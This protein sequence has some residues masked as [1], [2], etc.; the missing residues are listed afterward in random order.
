MAQQLSSALSSFIRDIFG[1]DQK[2]RQELSISASELV[3]GKHTS[4]FG[5]IDASGLGGIT[6]ALGL[7]RRL[8]HR[9]ADYEQMD[10]YGDINAAL[11]I[12]ADD[13]TQTDST[14]RKSVWIESQDEPVRKELE[15]MLYNRLQIEE[16]VWEIARQTCL[17][18]DTKVWGSGK[19]IK[20]LEP[21]DKVLC[22][23]G[24]LTTV[25]KKVNNGVRDVLRIKTRHRE[26]VATPDH[27][28]L[29]EDEDGNR[30]WVEAGDLF[31][32]RYPPSP[33]RKT[34]NLHD[35]NTKIVVSGF[36]S[37]GTIPSWDELLGEGAVESL[38]ESGKG[39]SNE[40]E[41]PKEI[42]PWFCRL[43]G[44]LLGDG[45]REH[46][47]T[48]HTVVYARGEYEDQND[49]YDDLLSR[50]GLKVNVIDRGDGV[51]SKVYSIKFKR[52]LL[53]LDWIDGSSNKRIP[54]WVYNLPEEFR[55]EFLWGFIDTDGW[56]SSPAT[57]KQSA[58]H[59]EI[60]NR[61]LAY[62]FKTLIDGLGYRSGNIR[63]RKRKPGFKIKEKVVKTTKIAYMLT[64]S[65]IR[66]DEQFFIERVVSV[67][68]HGQTEVFDIEVKSE[69]SSFSAAGIIVHNCKYGNDFE[70]IVV[71]SNG[72]IGLNFLPPATV[73]RV[74]GTG[75]ELLGFV[76]SYSMD[77]NI[78]RN[79]FKNLKT[80]HGGAVSEG[81]DMAVFEDWRVA[82]FRLR[83]K[84]RDSVYGW[85]VTDPAR[86]AWR[87]LILLEDSV[88]VYR[89][90]RSP[91]RYAFYVDVGSMSNREAERAL[92]SV[93]QKLKKRKF[94][95]PRTGKLDFRYNPL[96]F[97]EDFFLGVRDG[98]ESTRVDV[99]NGPSYQQV[100][101]VQYFLFKL[102]AALK[103]PRAYLGYDENQPSKA[104]LCLA[105]DTKIP[106]LD[107]TSPTIEEL[108]KRDDPF[109]VYSVDKYNNMVPGLGRNARLTRKK[110]ATVEVE[111]DNGEII[112]C[113]P[114]H[115]IMMRD[116]SYREAQELNC[117]DSLMPLYRKESDSSMVGYEEVYNP[118]DGRWRFT[119][120]MVTD[121]L[122]EEV[123][124]GD[125]RHHDNFNKRD[126][127]PDNLHVMSWGDH[128]E[129]HARHAEKTLLRPDVMRKRLVA[130]KEWLDSK[131]GQI[132]IRR[133]LVD[134]RGEG[135][136]YQ[137]R[138]KSDSYRKDSSDR[139]L[140]RHADPYDE[141]SRYNKSVR[142][143]ENDRRHSVRMS[144]DG[145]PKW[146]DEA[147]FEV[148][149]DV[150]GSY[151]CTSIAQLSKWT[152]YSTTL[153][154]RLIA[155]EGMTYREFAEEF[156]ISSKF[157]Q[158][159]YKRKYKNHK[160]VAVRVGPV[161]DTYDLTVDGYNNFAIEQGI[162]VHNSQEDVR[163]ARTVLRV[164]REIRN[165]LRKVCRVHLASRR[166]DPA[167]VDFEV[168]MTVPSSIF[169]L[170]QMEVRRTR[171]EIASSMERHVSLY[172]LLSNVY[173]MSD[174]EIS[175][176]MKQKEEE[177]KKAQ[178][179]G[180]GSQFESRVWTPGQPLPSPQITEKELMQGNREH[181]KRAEEFIKKQLADQNNLFGTQLREVGGLLKD[182]ARAQSRR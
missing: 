176:V 120:R 9:Y 37:G 112:T 5:G 24:S 158:N 74:Q 27:R 135:S 137:E 81:K 20:D 115:P 14:T 77:I 29:T 68:P 117:E 1:R 152:G 69:Q 105:G 126:N 102:Y 127:R 62:D 162:V 54:Q 123:Q 17:K 173:G 167:S 124:S 2:A 113:T 89:L 164:Q 36:V 122:F 49:Y 48:T 147:C 18:G 73:R 15:D 41:L 121:T 6:D 21:G 76:Q 11:D 59:F 166:I 138:M 51:Y 125:V 142:R 129:L 179:A 25:L 84:N 16:N 140:C 92:Q 145:N 19:E 177:M 66:F 40:L 114:D 103:V 3:R 91:S 44:F 154:Y 30:K 43:F 23:D 52:V 50:L 93:K 35:D 157:R 42:T 149:A 33:G 56:T 8:L 79:T 60:A 116:G 148:L 55:D 53:A 98:R 28:I 108:S 178:A 100:D 172:W 134:N 99:L 119:H 26:I 82:H 109:W 133:N 101:D 57:W 61:A 13:A 155:T 168:A 70:E 96:S 170:G 4:P 86:W 131:D 32:K 34:G 87:R 72:V 175:E 143:V 97:D 151:R 65:K 180:G 161:V 159:A 106:L 182:I 38:G 75:G 153:I 58:Y 130:Q 165:G 132:V 88:M 80:P 128:R 46:S 141:I 146:N 110:T 139:M 22:G 163:F 94:V 156:M 136:R 104:T 150:A 160:V 39:T 71:G 67:E 174:D 111:L 78:D 169:E 7:D 10:E 83:S 64:F 31:C 181:E 12:Y 118:G 144:G 85:A 95:N 45:F 107:G 63:G 90:T 171:A 47:K